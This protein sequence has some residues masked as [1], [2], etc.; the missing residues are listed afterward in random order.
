MEILLLKNGFNVIVDDY[1]VFF[2]DLW[3]VI[4]NGVTLNLKAINVLDNLIK[5]KKRFVLM[6]NAPRPQKSVANFLKK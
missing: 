3:G 1:E 5:K 6:S 4:H 2:I